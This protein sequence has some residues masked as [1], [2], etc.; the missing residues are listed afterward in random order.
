M[1]LWKKGPIAEAE[2]PKNISNGFF[3]RS[4]LRDVLNENVIRDGSF[5][6][7]LCPSITRCPTISVAVHTSLLHRVYPIV[8]LNVTEVIMSEVACDSPPCK[9]GDLVHPDGAEALQRIL[10]R[11][12]YGSRFCPLDR[13]E[14]YKTVCSSVFGRNAQKAFLIISSYVAIPGVRHSVHFRL[15]V[16]AN[17]C[18]RSGLF[19]LLHKVGENMA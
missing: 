6:G 19:L 10:Q 5:W 16:E 11:P 8:I 13:H 14:L 7:K 17:G 1:A 4:S 9:T 18:L 3:F 12:S 2:Q 15:V